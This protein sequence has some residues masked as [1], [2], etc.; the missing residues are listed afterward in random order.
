MKTPSRQKAIKHLSRKSYRSLA[1]DLLDSPFKRKNLLTQLAL[2]IKKEMK[3]LA[4]D[5]YDTILKDTVKMFSWETVKLELTRKMPTLTSLLSQLVPKPEE[6]TALI[7]MIASQLLKCR[8]RQ[9][10]LVQRAVSVMFYG[11]GTVKQVTTGKCMLDWS[12]THCSSRPRG[13][14]PLNL[15]VTSTPEPGSP[16]LE[17]MV[18]RVSLYP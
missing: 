5:E 6:H 7:C 14:L 3:D 16:F 10:C 2:R 18:S 8:H 15:I 17:Q 4:S 11:N 12:S 1:T 9:L 13:L